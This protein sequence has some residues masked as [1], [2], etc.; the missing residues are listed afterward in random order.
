MAMVPKMEKKR[1]GALYARTKANTMA[2]NPRNTP[3]MTE[4]LEGHSVQNAWHA[5]AIVN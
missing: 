1:N 3:N 4:D 5:V 2:P